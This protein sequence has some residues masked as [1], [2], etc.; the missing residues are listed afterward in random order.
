MMMPVANAHSSQAPEGD[1]ASNGTR[2][3][4]IRTIRVRSS[5]GC[6]TGVVDQL[7]SRSLARVSGVAVA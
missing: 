3:V 6:Q 4:S 5:A 1:D 2:L 7:L